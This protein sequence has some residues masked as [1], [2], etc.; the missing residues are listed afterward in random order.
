M[1]LTDARKMYVLLREAGPTGVHS[2]DLRSSGTTGQP[3]QRAKDIASNGVPLATKREARGKRP[4]SRY[5]LAH[6][7]PP[8]ATPVQPNGGAERGGGSENSPETGSA[9]PAVAL[10]IEPAPA[11]TLEPV[12]IFRDFTDPEGCWREIPVSELGRVA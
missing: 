3:S 5:W 12:A 6:F 11:D 4:G 1:S 8:D 7:A 10:S 2:H 9:S